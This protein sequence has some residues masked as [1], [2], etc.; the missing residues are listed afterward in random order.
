MPMHKSIRK[1]RGAVLVTALVFLGVITM[2]S[3]TSMRSSTIG[4]RL[5]QNEEARFA[6]LEVAQA[7]TEIVAADANT[8]P[9]VGG[10]GYTLCTAGESGCNTYGVP[11]PA[12]HVADQVAQGNLSVRIER[13]TPPDKPPPR[14]LESSIDTFRAASFRVVADYD[15]SDEGLGRA[16]LVEGLIVLVPGN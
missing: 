9:I 13:M 11:L 8:T 4:V 12:G 7:M 6:A 1:Q 15:R 16:R 10:A 3:V 5:A 2:L 14:V